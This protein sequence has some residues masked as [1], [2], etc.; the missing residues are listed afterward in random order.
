MGLH[1]R[2]AELGWLSQYPHEE[3]LAFPPLTQVELHS[4]RIDGS[5]IVVH[6]RV[7]TPQA[8]GTSDDMVA[9]MK[10]SHLQ[11]VDMLMNEM[12]QTQ[13]P[14]GRYRS[15]QGTLDH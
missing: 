15:L 12:I 5:T 9:K 6:T 4:T 3:E 8:E 13:V 7:Q 14:A 1:C 10:N 11:L 2:G